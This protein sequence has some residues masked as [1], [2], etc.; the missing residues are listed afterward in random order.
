MCALGCCGTVTG[1]NHVVHPCLIGRR[2]GSNIILGRVGPR[3]L[4]DSVY[5]SSA[6]NGL[7]NVLHDII[8]FNAGHHCNSGRF[9][10]TNGANATRLNCNANNIIHRRIDFYKCF[11][12]SGPV[13]D[14][15]IIIHRPRTPP[16]TKTVTNNIFLGITRHICTRGVGYRV[17]SLT[18]CSSDGSRRPGLPHIGGNSHGG[19]RRTVHHTKIEFS[20]SSS[21]S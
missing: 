8:R 16:T 2:I 15:V 11:P 6:L 19:A 10:V 12:T 1:K 7:R 18:E 20:D 9:T 17:S 21:N 3:I 13:C 5:G 14:Y 4:G